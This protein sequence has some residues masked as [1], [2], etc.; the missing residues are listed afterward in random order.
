M[1]K[2]KEKKNETM[3]ESRIT[4]H[5]PASGVGEERELLGLLFRRDGCREVA[6]VCHGMW[7]SMLAG[8]VVPPLCASLSQHMCVLRFDFAG[9]GWSGGGWKYAG[10][11]RD[12]EDLDAMIEHCETLGLKVAGI[13]GHSKA[14]AAV[15]LHAAFGRLR[16]DCPHVSIAGRISYSQAE[17]RFTAEELGMAREKGSFEWFKY[18]KKWK[19][20]QGDIDERRALDSKMK[21]GL[22]MIRCPVLHVHGTADEMVTVEDAKVVGGLVPR[23]EVQLLDGANHFFV[24]RE[25]ELCFR[26]C[27]WLIARLSAA[28][29]K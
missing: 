25:V 5:V 15:L 29:T 11:D 24:G 1:K 9:N 16:T 10:Y 6:V 18:G 8:A 22:T 19:I 26:V 13:I 23:A 2:K 20:T 12:V 21:S 14:G 17:S 3:V 4:A 7:G 27:L 28:S